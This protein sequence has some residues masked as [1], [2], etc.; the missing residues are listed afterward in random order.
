MDATLLEVNPFGETDDGRVV[1]FD[2]KLN[3]DDNASFRQKRVFA[4]DDMAESDPREV[5]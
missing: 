3:F 1:C 5:K 4:M 2:A